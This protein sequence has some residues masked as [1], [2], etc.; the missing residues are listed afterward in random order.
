[1]KIT[2][3]GSGTPEPYARR[4]SSGYLVEIADQKLLFDCGGGV[5]GRLLEIGVRPA[6]IDVLF[7]THL[8]SDHMMDYARLVHAAWDT[9]APPLR[10]YGPAPMAKISERFFGPDG[11]FAWDLKARTG[12]EPSQQVWQARGGSLPRPWPEPEI[13]EIEPGFT[14]E[15]RGWK[16]LSCE[17]PHAQ[18]FLSCLAFR[19]ETEAGSFVYSGD[20]GLCAE[21]ETLS[22]DADLLIHWCYRGEGES[23]SPELDAKS[24]TP[25]EIARMAK[26]V[27]VKRL[28]LSHI[29]E[30]MDEDARRQRNLAALKESFAGLAVIA[31][32]LEVFEI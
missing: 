10:V 20:A 23:I 24:P 25:S 15:G 9:G 16:L 29:R 17:V 4:A 30:H 13:T 3:L 12:Y 27:G 28:A 26:R 32:D 1:M 8:H 7:L 22:A 19:L 6:E 18:P 5:V 14:I 21:M 2:V 31:E 11:A